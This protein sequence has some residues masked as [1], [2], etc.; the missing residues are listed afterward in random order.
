MKLAFCR[1]KTIGSWLIRKITWSHWSHVAI[2][3]GDEIIE[4]T[5]PRVRVSSLDHLHFNHDEILIVEFPTDK[6]RDIIAFARSQLGKRYDLIGILGL[7]LHRDWQN[8]DQ[9][10]CSE[11]PAWCA[12]KAGVPFF[13]LEAVHTIQPQ[14]W[15][16]IYPQK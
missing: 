12:L 15:Y 8:E 3:D 1:S 4:A 2:V 11:L 16:M 6:D 5:Y 13:R 7:W 14:H 10:W 9:W